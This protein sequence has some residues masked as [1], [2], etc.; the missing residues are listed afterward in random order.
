LDRDLSGPAALSVLQLAEVREDVTGEGVDVADLVR[1]ADDPVGVDEIREPLGELHLVGAGVPHLVGHADL[2]VPVGEQPEREVE[3]L[4]ELPVRFRVVERRAEDD[5]IQLLELVGLVT[6]A[7][8]LD[9]SARCVGHRVPPEQDPVTP[10]TRQRDGLT[11]LVGQFEVRCG[12]SLGE[13]ADL[14]FSPLYEIAVRFRGSAGA[15]H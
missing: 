5:A 11:V 9:R 4:S 7:L 1:L 8:A 2:L 14:L 3:L 15:A 10:Q 13:H 12:G 6:Q